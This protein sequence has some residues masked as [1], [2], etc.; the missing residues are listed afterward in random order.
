M[1]IFGRI[2]RIV[3]LI[4][5]HP[6]VVAFVLLTSY[7]PLYRT[8]TP[9]WYLILASLVLAAVFLVLR[10]RIS[11]TALLYIIFLSDIPLAGAIIHST[12][13][14]ES[15]FPL[16]YVILILAGSMYLYRRGA[17]IIAISATVFFLGLVFFQSRGLQGY[18]MS[19]VLYRFYVFGLLFL[20]VG[21]LSGG[22]SESYQR[23]VE[24]AARL[25]LTTEDIIRNL[26][27]GVITVDSRGDIL[28]TN[29][30]DS[31][32]RAIVHLHVAR[33]MNDRGTS[34]SFELRFNDRYYVLSCVRIFDGKAGLAILQDM[35]ELRRLEESSRVASETK[36]LAELGGSLAHEIRNPLSSIMGSL[37]VIRD[38]K[39]R[40][41][42]LPFVEMALKETKRLNDIVTDFLNFSQFTPKNR[43]KVRIGEVISEALL[44][45][46]LREN[47]KGLVIKRRDEDFSVLCDMDKLKSGFTNILNNAYEVSGEKNTIEIRSY[48]RMKQGCV[49][50]RDHGPGIEQ[51]NLKRVFEPFYTTKKGGTGLGLAI[52]WNII[53]AHNGSISVDSKVG[54]GTTFVVRLPLA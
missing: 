30:S 6:F 15:L 23:R 2:D 21:I 14:I 39:G 44:G 8:I 38:D 18:A 46:L 7:P 47:A 12:G 28:Y 36:L 29:M 32:L 45:S 5:V 40:K 49:E 52:A 10:A 11:A 35:T 3:G 48:R 13:G 41:K 33:F 50:I 24:E 37:E 26:P 9:A 51:D 16:I 42:A 19:V 4:I 53:S 27:S 34:D 1:K 31:R 54:E 43:N 17:Y 25:R 22:L 20:L